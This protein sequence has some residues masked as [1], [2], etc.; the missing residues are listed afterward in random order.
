[1]FSDRGDI[2]HGLL[3]DEGEFRISTHSMLVLGTG[4]GK[5]FKASASDCHQLIV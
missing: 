2:R 3:G 5:V 4:I 1:M